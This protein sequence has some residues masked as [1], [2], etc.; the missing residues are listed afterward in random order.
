[1]E[2][3]DYL[4]AMGK[5]KKEY[6]RYLEP[7]CKDRSLT[8][9][10]LAVLLFLY[11][12]PGRDRAADIVRGRGMSKG[13]VSLSLRS[14]EARGL[15]A[16]WEDEEDR[17]TVRLTLTDNGG[18]IAADG[19]AAQRDFFARIRAGITSEESQVMRSVTQKIS[20]NILALERE[21]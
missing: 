5:A 13:H 7:V 18:K 2:I 4:D 9:N 3:M 11:N 10:E 19:Q 12:N 21:L 14:L 16:R 8:Q 17:R 15:V 20:E 6:L 1:M